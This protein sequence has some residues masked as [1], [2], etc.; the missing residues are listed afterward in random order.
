MN[1]SKFGQ[2]DLHLHLDGSLP[3]E[4]ILRI[5]KESGIRLPADTAE[6]LKPYICAGMDCKSLNEYLG[7]FDTVLKVLQTERGLCQAARELGENLKVRGLRYAEVRFAPQLHCH[8]GMSQEQAVTAVL[9]GL[10]KAQEDSDIRLRT[11][12][13]CMRG[14]DNKKANLQTVRLASRYL[15]KGV[16]AVDLA[17]AEALFP[18]ADY[19]EEFALARKLGVPFTIHAG[20]AAG[21]ASIRKAV[22]FGAARIGHGVR[23]IE[24]EELMELLASREIPLE[25]CPISNLQTKAVEKITDYPLRTYLRRGIKVTVNSDNMTVSDTW[26]GKEFQYLADSYGLTEAEAE[27]LLANA[28]FAAFE[29]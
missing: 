27:Q 21:P 8:K 10:S 18:T 28:H 3:A 2:I 24:D 13:C 19:E 26:V 11:I 6:G 20:E 14:Q 5:A 7:C 22:E 29:A 1:M 4:T 12:L 16:V 25:M 15:G 9:S 23:A 17:G